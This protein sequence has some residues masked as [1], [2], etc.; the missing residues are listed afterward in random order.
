MDSEKDSKRRLHTFI[1]MSKN[2]TSNGSLNELIKDIISDVI[3]ATEKADAGFLLLWDE[4]EKLLRIEAAVNFREEM[5]L[6]NTLLPGEGISGRVFAEGKSLLLHREE[7]GKA[8]ENM[9]NQTMEYYLKSTID[10]VMP[11]SCVSVPLTHMNQKIGVLTIDNF[12]NASHF[13]EEDVQ[14]LEAIG[15]QIA[16]SIV[17][18][19]AFYEK[20]KHADELEK[21]LSYHNQLNEAALKGNGLQSL[22]E[23]LA[24]LV[25]G[26]IFYFDPLYRYEFSSS[27]ADGNIAFLEEWLRKQ[28]KSKITSRKPYPIWMADHLYGY[29]L[30]IESSFG[31]VGY[32]IMELGGRE[33]DTVKELV[34]K[35]AVSLFA[36][37]RIKFQEQT[38]QAREEK[39]AILKELLN[40]N[41][42][43]AVQRSLIRSGM[44][45]T[46][47]YCF[48]AVTSERLDFG[49]VHE[50]ITLESELS[51]L[52]GQARH[53]MT[54]PQEKS[55]F[56]LVNFG[57]QI[58]SPL[59]EIRRLSNRLLSLFTDL[60]ISAGRVVRTLHHVAIS[61]E[62]AD[63]A[64]RQGTGFKT[65]R[66]LGFKR[67]LMDMSEEE[68]SYFIEE[69]IG[70][71][72]PQTEAGDRNELLKT[73]KIY[74]NC[75]KHA[76]KTARAL[77]V[78][79][80]TVYYRIQQL[81]EKLACDFDDWGHV[82]NLHAAMILY[83][84]NSI[85]T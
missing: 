69:M 13:N 70:S 83:E 7:I 59:E 63:Y 16:I 28:D 15:H 49:E 10:A 50:M 60:S 24:G 34:I 14:F 79:T 75:N 3:E 33:L 6:Q 73:L 36:M 81:E 42:T 11:I 71:I 84:R 68:A 54:F 48:V 67:Y 8:M 30:S 18:A 52:S 37:E 55:I 62:D 45:I 82:M 57:Q 66:D 46:G 35:H 21:I 43:A 72:L 1:Q 12:H 17:N 58:K 65:F 40:R 78:H 29:A 61:Y 38:K 85:R 26:R 64:S 19:R 25:G 32:L 20:Q 9:R 77:H 80:N 56:L 76:G 27:R 5:Y 23:C 44:P 74:L 41:L 39:G 22:V 51:R 31:T 4:R 2:I 47:Q 53:V